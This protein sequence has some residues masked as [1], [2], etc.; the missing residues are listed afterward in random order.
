MRAKNTLEKY[1]FFV[2]N[3]FFRKFIFS[4]HKDK[5]IDPRQI[6]RIII[7]FFK[8]HLKVKNDEMSK[9]YLLSRLLVCGRQPDSIFGVGSVSV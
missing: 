3:R 7:I 1:I 4:T 5:Y 6:G 9:C 8:L 2:V